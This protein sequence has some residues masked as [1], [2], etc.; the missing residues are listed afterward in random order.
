MTKYTTAVVLFALIGIGLCG[1]AASQAK[2]Y[3]C[4]TYCYTVMG[5]QICNTNCF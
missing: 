3:S 2:A 4:T 1:F 5:R